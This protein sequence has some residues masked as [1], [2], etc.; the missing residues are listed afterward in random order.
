MPG[1]VQQLRVID[2]T[3]GPVGGVATMV[4]ADFG[5]DVVKVERPGGDPFRFMASAPVW[6][7]GKRSVVL[8]LKT[9]AG[10]ADL[11]RL[12]ATADLVLTTGTEARLRRLGADHETLAAANPAIV[13]CAITAFGPTGPYAEYPGYEGVVAAK[14]GRMASFAG[15]VQRDGP[16]FAALRVASHHTA[17]AAVFG[18]LAA[19]IARDRTGRGQ[20][21]DTSLL[22]GLSAY[23]L[24]SLMQESLRE[25]DP[26]RW[27]EPAIPPPL[28]PTINYHPIMTKDGA[29][30]Q[31]GNLLQHLFDNF[32]VAADLADIY[33]DGAHEG[34]PATWP[35]ATREAFRDRMLLH[36]RERTAEEW[37]RTFIEHGGVAAHRYQSTQEALDDPDLTANGHVVES[38]HPYDPARPPMRQIGV[39]ARLTGTPGA[40]R[41]AFPAVG[42][43]TD[44]V[45]GEMPSSPAP[46]HSAGGG[47]RP[48]A[49]PLDGITV[50]DFSTI[51]A[52]PLAAT[53]LADLGARVIKMEQVGGDPWRWMYQGLGFAKTNAGKE[54][55]AL[56]LKRAEGRAIAHALIAKADVLIHNYRP[57]VPERLGIGYEDARAIRPDIVYVSANGYGLA[58]P[59]AHRPATHPIAGAAAGGAV[60]QSGGMPAGT[61][62]EELREGARRLSRANEVNPDPNTSAV[63]AAAT[64]LALWHRQRTGEGQQL[65]TDMMGANVYANI[66]DFF[67][68]EG[69]TP[70]PPVDPEILGTGPLYRLYRCHE[71]WVFLGVVLDREWEALCAAI[72]RPD[73]RAHPDYATREGREAHAD[74]LAAALAEVFATR[75]AYWWEA[76]LTAK[77]IGCV[78]A[79]GPLPGAFWHTDPHVAANGFTTSVAHF[80][81]GPYERYRGIA[82]VRGAD[83]VYGPAPVGGEHAAALLRE[84]GYDDAAIEALRASGVVWSEPQ[85]LDRRP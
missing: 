42:E 56:D 35:E 34:S 16:Q 51:I 44:E 81:H 60:W 6:L 32:L 62:L 71:G 13:T 10:R 40:V 74:A 9:E 68:Y 63:I 25:R 41:A 19:L 2:L 39:L 50:L 49:P 12:A 21:V 70:R 36:M 58:G 47:A 85:V 3:S 15:L 48:D 55:I 20:R 65:F 57:G 80:E 52:A 1:P 59:G 27:T 7:R 75:D 53:H 14:A 31:L 77:G 23:D 66:D 4:L 5:A 38:P 33:A 83:R 67:T 37:M 17:L 79:D 61:S 69:R 84:L 82:R 24:V 22:Q 43:H 73:L 76:S 26:E 78:R 29:W 28:M 46:S 18:S 8:D 72:G 45:L 30:L 54:S 64:L 11:A